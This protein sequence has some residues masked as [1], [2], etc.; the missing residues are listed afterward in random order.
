MATYGEPDVVELAAAYALAW[1]AATLSWTA[2]STAFI[3]ARMNCDSTVIA[4]TRRTS[5]A[6]STTLA[7]AAGDI[8]E[9]AFA[10]WLL[11]TCRCAD[12]GR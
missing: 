4:S 10:A 6:W 3:A 1:F 9:A 11:A 7:L 2:T 5:T 8:D 12:P